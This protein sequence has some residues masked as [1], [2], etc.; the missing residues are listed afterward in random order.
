MLIMCGQFVNNN[1]LTT[2]RSHRVKSYVRLVPGS[3]LLLLHVLHLPTKKEKARADAWIPW[4]HE[5]P[6]WKAGACSSQAER[7][8][9]THGLSF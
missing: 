4:P 1:Q 8:E 6:H 3:S 9:K 5:L 7:A 2:A